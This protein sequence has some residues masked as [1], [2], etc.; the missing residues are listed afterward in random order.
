MKALAGDLPQAHEKLGSMVRG[1]EMG[2]MTGAFM[3]FPAGTDLCPLLAGLPNDHCQ[4]PHW[5]YVIDGR[6]TVTYE[7]GSV[8]TVSAGELYYW[9]PGH[10]VKFE[11]DT[12][13]VEFS[14]KAEM[15]AV[16]DHVTAKM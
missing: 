2:E 11:E 9:P 7:D 13:Y 16:L 8:E 1:A 6:I 3:N 12:R 5:G 14:P 15:A 10:V 4:C